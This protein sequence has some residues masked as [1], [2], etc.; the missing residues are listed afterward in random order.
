MVADNIRG[1]AAQSQNI[2]S[3]SFR[4]LQEIDDLVQNSR[5]AT[6]SL[7][8]VLTKIKADTRTSADIIGNINEEISSQK[9]EF[10]RILQSVRNLSHESKKINDLSVRDRQE[11]EQHI[12]SFTMM[13]DSFQSISGQLNSQLKEGEYLRQH[14]DQLRDLMMD[15]SKAAEDLH[16][17]LKEDA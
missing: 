5:E 9:T 1:L 3:N 13:K 8:A 15:T 17:L 2:V 14:L 16:S 7:G 11:K 4:N 10:S 6:T 12:K